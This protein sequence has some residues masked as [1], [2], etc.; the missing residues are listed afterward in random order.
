MA[1]D[2][3]KLNAPHVVTPFKNEYL[4]AIHIFLGVV[5]ALSSVIAVVGN[6]I[7]L[8][9][10]KKSPSLHSPSYVLLFSL[11]ISD[12]GVGLLVQPLYVM[13]LIWRATTIHELPCKVYVAYAV[14]ASVFAAVSYFMIA[15][16]SIDRFLAVFLR[17]TYRAVVT[18]KRSVTTVVLVWV[19][20]GVANGATRSGLH[21]SSR[22]AFFVSVSIAATATFT[23][24]TVAF[25]LSIRIL[26]QIQSHVQAQPSSREPQKSSFNFG[27][28]KRSV[29]SMLYVY[30]LFVIC[31]LP[32]IFFFA[33][34][35][36][37][38]DFLADFREIFTTTVYLNSSI[39]PALYYWRMK[40]LRQAIKNL[41]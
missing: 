27:R 18:M 30:G 10:I 32:A 29:Y 35:E 37:F 4:L 16:L 24:T 23:A 39:N 31:Y 21:K 15:I 26:R 13:L 19:L 38:G 28:Y 33:V 40:D 8:V 22:F 20:A 9:A 34:G 1:D 14:F 11:A 7:V 41:F 3:C 5:N 12:L 25:F 2:V 17:L 36:F 6:I